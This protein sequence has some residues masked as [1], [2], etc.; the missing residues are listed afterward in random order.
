M[1]PPHAAKAATTTWKRTIVSYAKLSLVSII[2]N[3][4]K[5]IYLNTYLSSFSL[6]VVALHLPLLFLLLFKRDLNVFFHGRGKQNRYKI[7]ITLRADAALSTQ[8]NAVEFETFVKSSH[9]QSFSRG[10]A[11]Y[12]LR[13]IDG[14][15]R[16]ARERM[17]S[18]LCNNPG[19]HWQVRLKLRAGEQEQEPKTKACSSAH[20]S[21]DKYSKST[22]AATAAEAVTVRN[23]ESET[24]KIT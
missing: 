22:G 23:G 15:Q 11:H 1:S 21:V 4:T 19:K 3:V 16:T 6:S 18:I 9:A 8:Q 20:K 13:P 12:D 7:K 5:F 14:G 17:N 2:D 10:G 24:A